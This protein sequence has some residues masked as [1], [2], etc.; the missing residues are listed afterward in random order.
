LNQIA[1]DFFEQLTAVALLHHFYR[2]LTRPESRQLHLLR[3]APQAIGEC[4][5]E[6][7]GR[8]RDGQA[9]TERSD[10]LH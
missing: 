5:L 6:L 8:H 9:S 4:F 2:H 3:Q 7:L 10:R 1:G